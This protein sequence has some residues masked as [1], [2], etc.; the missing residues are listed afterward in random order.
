M[1]TIME[2]NQN[3]LELKDDFT[4]NNMVNN[5]DLFDN[6]KNLLQLFLDH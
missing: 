5:L 4:Q 3:M 2:A 1:D 6:Q